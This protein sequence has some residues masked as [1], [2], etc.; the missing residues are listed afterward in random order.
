MSKPPIEKISGTLYVENKLRNIAQVT[1]EFFQS[2]K[3]QTKTLVFPYRA[4]FFY[5]L[6]CVTPQRV[7]LLHKKTYCTISHCIIHASISPVWHKRESLLCL[8][9]GD[10][11]SSRFTFDVSVWN[12]WIKQKL[13]LQGHRILKTQLLSSVLISPKLLCKTV[14]LHWYHTLSGHSSQ[15]P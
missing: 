7:I 8:E 14:C 15:W 13:L 4:I 9:V 2:N 5:M 6:G 12:S 1:P 11:L 10:L 3:R